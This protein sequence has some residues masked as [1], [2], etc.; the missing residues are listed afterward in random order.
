MKLGISTACLYP[1]EAEKSLR[2]L[3]HANFNVFE[4]FL[5]TFREMDP[6]FLLSLKTQ[7]DAVNGQIV[8]VHP[9]TSAFETTLLFSSY[10]RRFLDG[11]EIYKRYCDCAVKLG[12]NIVVLHGQRDYQ[13]SGISEETYLQRYAKL[14][15]AA[16]ENGVVLAQEN[17]N[18]FRSEKITFIRRMREVLKDECAFVLDVKQAVRAGEDPYAMCKEM[19]NRIV[20]VHLN[21]HTKLKDCVLPGLGNMDYVRLKS[22]L[23]AQNYDGPVLI[24]VYRQ[25][26]DEISDLVEAKN[27]MDR[28]FF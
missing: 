3:L 14:Y 21:D 6:R 18:R 23:Q 15:Q 2:A 8:S 19:G 26:F 11:V 13:G 16:K 24:E 20:N 28:V 12:A 22:L 27:R 10:E 25:D 17:V 1:M 9:F 5:N 7:V 4:I